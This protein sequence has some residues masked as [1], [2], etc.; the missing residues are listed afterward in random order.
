MGCRKL[1]YYFRDGVSYDYHRDSAAHFENSLFGKTTVA[2]G[3]IPNRFAFRFSS[4]YHDSETGLVYYNYRYYSP[5]LGRWLSRDLMEEFGGWNLYAMLG[6]NAVNRIDRLGLIGSDDIYRQGNNVYVNNRSWYSFSPDDYVGGIVPGTN[7]VRIGYQD[8][9]FVDIDYNDLVEL[10]ENAGLSSRDDIF[11]RIMNG[12]SGKALG[13]NDGASVSDYFDLRVRCKACCDD[14]VAEEQRCHQDIAK[15]FGAN[16][17]STL[18]WGLGEGTGVVLATGL[19][20]YAFAHSWNPTGWAAGGV[21][22]GLTGLTIKDMY[23]YN[24]IKSA[25]LEAIEKYCVCPESCKK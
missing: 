9:E 2:S 6:N 4:E 18:V 17:A 1:Q 14:W 5:E 24:Q 19:S 8:G 10:A 7:N 12:N 16:A 23:D 3:T 25:G 11:D 15:R 13:G 22:L 21:A 20:T